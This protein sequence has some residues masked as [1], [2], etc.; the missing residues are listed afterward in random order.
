MGIGRHATESERKRGMQDQ[1]T[2]TSLTEPLTQAVINL[3]KR[4]GQLAREK[5]A[6][7]IAVAYQDIT[8]EILAAEIARLKAAK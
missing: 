8:I 7:R 5:E 1:V 4:N 2:T 6:L 3:A